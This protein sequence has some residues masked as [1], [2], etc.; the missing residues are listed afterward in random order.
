[1]KTKHIRNISVFLGLSFLSFNHSPS[2]AQQCTLEPQ[3]GPDV[4]IVPAGV[5]IKKL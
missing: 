4:F 3:T 2:L 1:M 5:M